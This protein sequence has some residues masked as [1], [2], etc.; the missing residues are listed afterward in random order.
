MD[1]SET[2]AHIYIHNFCLYSTPVIYCRWAEHGICLWMFWVH[3][4]PFNG[5]ILGE[6]MGKT[7]LVV[8]T[9]LYLRGCVH[10]ELCL[11]MSCQGH[12]AIYGHPLRTGNGGD[13]VFPW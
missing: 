6:K 3:F 4:W 5:D 13:W 2:F 11:V 10:A 9:Q 8:V 7:A 12:E 1:N